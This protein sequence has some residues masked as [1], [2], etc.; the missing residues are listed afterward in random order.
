MNPGNKEIVEKESE[1]KDLKQRNHLL[2]MYPSL[3]VSTCPFF[4]R[5]LEHEKL[6]EKGSLCR[7]LLGIG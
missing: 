1:K 3:P 6:S 7:L 4:G 5:P 2:M